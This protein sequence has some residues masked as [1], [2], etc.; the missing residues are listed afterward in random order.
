LNPTLRSEDRSVANTP[1]TSR[2]AKKAKDD[3]VLNKLSNSSNKIRAGLKQKEGKNGNADDNDNHCSFD[4][5]EEDY[6]E[7]DEDDG[8]K[9]CPSVGLQLCSGRLTLCLVCRP[10]SSNAGTSAEVNFKAT[11]AFLESCVGAAGIRAVRSG[12]EV[13]DLLGRC[14]I[15]LISVT[16]RTEV[17]VG[18]LPGHP[19]HASAGIEQYHGSIFR[20]NYQGRA[21]SICCLVNVSPKLNQAT[22]TIHVS[23]LS[24]DVQRR[25]AMLIR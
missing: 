7:D 25:I 24:C 2:T 5:E 11:F 19:H 4:E 17:I 20:S 9:W 21:A 1:R 3:R 10:V 13:C 14:I 6:G 16:C 8:N 15:A 22:Y 18:T 23:N 12:L